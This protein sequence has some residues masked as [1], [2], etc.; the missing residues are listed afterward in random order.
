M[1]ARPERTPGRAGGTPASPPT[2]RPAPPERQPLAWWGAIDVARDGVVRVTAGP[3]Q[4]WVER[5]RH[6][7]RVFSDATPEADAS[8]GAEPDATSAEADVFPVAE[9]PRTVDAGDLPDA[10]PRVRFCFADAPERLLV[11]VAQAD[12]PFVVR[13]ATPVSVGPGERVTLFVS[14]PTWIVLS[15]ERVARK[16]PGTRANTDTAPRTQK[17]IEFPL[18]RPSDT[19]FGPN[20]LEGELCYATRTAG[21]LRLDDVP[22][23]P[24]LALT[25]VLIENK[26]DD[27][28]Q[29]ER[30]R[31]PLPQLAVYADTTGALWTNAVRLTRETGGD[32]A[33]VQVESGVPLGARGA[34]ERLTTPR[35]E[36]AKGSVVRAFSRLLHFAGSGT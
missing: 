28:L 30:V 1:V 15:V 26:D 29:F 23:H 11:S 8:T 27:P 34:S 14:T 9:R 17:L 5:R 25:P 22:R 2:P 35:T 4:V 18:E 21:Y 24:H 7:W 36:S 20:T 10:D 3:T 16:R 6:D 19:W 13:P 33:S 32:L 31:V 12:R